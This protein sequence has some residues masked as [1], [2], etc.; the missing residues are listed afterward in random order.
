MSGNPPG[1][2][3]GPPQPTR[4]S[5]R[6]KK[7]RV[8]TV[9]GHRILKENNYVVRGGKYQFFD[10]DP[11]T[12]TSASIRLKAKARKNAAKK[13]NR[14]KPKKELTAAQLKRKAQNDRIRESLALVEEKREVFFSNHLDTV[15]PFI[16]PQLVAKLE[17]IQSAAGKA[18]KKEETL[19]LQPSTIQGDMRDYQL[20]GLNWMVDMYNQGLSMILGDEMGLGKS[21]QSISIIAHLLEK[22]ISGPFLVVCPLSVLSSWMAEFKKWCPTLNVLRFHTNGANRETLRKSLVADPSRYDVILTTYDYLKVEKTFWP[23]FKFRLCIMDEGHILK[24][25]ETLLSKAARSI[26]AESRIILT[27]T[28]LQ[29]NL[30]ELWAIL[31]YL[32]PQYFTTSKP[33]DEA[34]DLS[35]S[36]VDS[37]KLTLA[38]KL[39]KLFM[40]RRLKVEVEKLLPKKVETTVFCPLSMCQLYWYKGLVVKDLSLLA[41]MEQSVDDGEAASYSSYKVL[42][43]LVMQLRKVCNHPYLFA[44]A[45]PNPENTTVKELLETSGKLA[46]LDKLLMKLFSKGHRVVIFSQFTRILDMIDDYC[47]MRGWLYSRLDGSTSRPLRKL[48][49][50]EFNKDGSK[51]FLFLMSTRAGGLGINL[52]T[53]DTCIL[54]DSDWNPQPDLQAMARVHRIGQKKTVHVYRLVC[55]GTV[56]ERIIERARKKLYLDQMVNRGSTKISS[57]LESLTAKELLNSLKFGS[58]AVFGEGGTQTLPTDDDIEKII[59]R[60]RC[61]SDSSGNLKGNAATK[62]ADFNPE[63]KSAQSTNF[64]GIDFSALRQKN[65]KKMSQTELGVTW[66]KRVSKKRIVMVQGLG[67]GYGAAHV[68]VLAS[69]NY[70]LEDGEPSVMDKELLKYKQKAEKKKKKAR[71]FT[72]QMS[73]QHCGESGEL[74]LCSQC[75]N[76]VHIECAGFKKLKEVRGAWSCS[77][78]SCSAC[79]NSSSEAGGLIFRCQGCPNAYCDDCLPKSAQVLMNFTRFETEHSYAMKPTFLYINCGPLCEEVAKRDFGWSQEKEAAASYL[80]DV[81]DVSTAYTAANKAA[82]LSENQPGDGNENIQAQP[83]AKRQRVMPKPYNPDQESVRHKAMMA[84][85]RVVNQY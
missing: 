36:Q 32:F 55:G 64:M 57:D 83:V 24:N 27:G 56:E 74:L 59:D 43:N 16:E 42:N 60:T 11:S 44:E 49:V 21:L 41:N 63:A 4:V 66:K 33:F 47:Y 52:Q 22:N 14:K 25:A 58:D 69:N 3:P 6:E 19:Y 17:A 13:D 39:L 5:K 84:I 70:D 30:T 9:D 38:H 53:A 8:I 71:K 85:Q 20:E 37:E 72:H 35:K 65:K 48:R 76:S 62:A 67:S 12:E 73:C 81:I 50:N 23:T 28:P 68:P 46:V 77:H 45:E 2:V 40:L 51:T 75:P 29:N 54:Y 78:H 34:F 7:S 79:G 26:H 10:V 82:A 61:K 15:R 80:P 18:D 31:N 1:T